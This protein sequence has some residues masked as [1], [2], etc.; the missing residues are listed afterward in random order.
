MVVNGRQLTQV[1]NSTVVIINT[2]GIFV[3]RASCCACI[4]HY[5]EHYDDKDDDDDDDPMRSK[6]LADI[7]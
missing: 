3:S 2:C 1:P 5:N 7:A 6:T 4:M